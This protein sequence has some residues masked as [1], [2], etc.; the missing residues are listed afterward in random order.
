MTRVEI[1]VQPVERAPFWCNG[2]YFENG[3][4]PRN[5][6]TAIADALESRGIDLARPFTMQID[7]TAHCIRAEQPSAAPDMQPESVGP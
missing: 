4:L 7:T 3:W 5:A 6:V 1:M 2:A